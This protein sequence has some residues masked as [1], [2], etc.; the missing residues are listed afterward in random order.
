MTVATLGAILAMAI[1]ALVRA[2]KTGK[3]ATTA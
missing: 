3:A 2:R 1:T